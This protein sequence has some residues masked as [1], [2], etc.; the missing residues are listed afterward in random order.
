MSED[1]VG[2]EG[3]S[4]WRLEEGGCEGLGIVDVER[5]VEVVN[6]VREVGEEAAARCI[7]WGG[8]V[9]GVERWG[10][11][12]A[13]GDTF[14]VMRRED[15]VLGGRWALWGVDGADMFPSGVFV[16]W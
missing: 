2:V 4:F 7:N 13:W 16:L 3:L 15:M 9:S 5:G 6:G 14:M 12:R 10:E 11:A 1:V 8:G